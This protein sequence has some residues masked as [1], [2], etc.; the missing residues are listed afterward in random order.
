[1]R[2]RVKCSVFSGQQR[3]RS[4]SDLFLT[5]QIAL[6]SSSNVYAAYRLND[7][8]KREDLAVKIV[9]C[10]RN[11]GE[12]PFLYEDALGWLQRERATLGRLD[13]PSIGRAFLEDCI[14]H[15]SESIVLERCCV[16]LRQY[17]EQCG[18]QV[19]LLSLTKFSCLHVKQGWHVA[20]SPPSATWTQIRTERIDE[21]VDGWPKHRV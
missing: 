9:V 12:W 11:A 16:D 19:G 1:M 15:A 13:H 14:K 6:G 5:Q 18:L 3:L 4:R 21:C 2:L 20:T 7:P 17:T 8:E 10:Y